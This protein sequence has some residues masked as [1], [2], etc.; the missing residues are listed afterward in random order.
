MADNHDR[1][2]MALHEFRNGTS[3]P[4]MEIH[5]AFAVWRVYPVAGR[6]AGQCPWLAFPIAVMLFGDHGVFHHGGAQSLI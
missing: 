6:L 2:F 1:A 3:D 5:M 4:L